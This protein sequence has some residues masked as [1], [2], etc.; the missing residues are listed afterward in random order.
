MISKESKIFQENNS[1]MNTP[2]IM[3]D[4]GTVSDAIKVFEWL[5]MEGEEISAGQVIF[6]VESDKAIM[7]VEAAISGMVFKIVV[8]AGGLVKPGEAVAFITSRDENIDASVLKG[9][10]KL[11]P[12]PASNTQVIQKLVESSHEGKKD[13]VEITPKAFHFAKVNQINTANVK[14]SGPQ[15]RIT[16]QD[17]ESVFKIGAEKLNDEG[18]I[19]ELKGLRGVIARNVSESAQTTA[20]VTTM[21]E[22]RA[23]RFVELRNNLR[24][25]LKSLNI[26][27]PYDLVLAKI[28]A[29]ALLEYS[30]MNSSLTPEGIIQHSAINI[31]IAIDTPEGLIVPVFANVDKRELAELALELQNKLEKAKNKLLSPSDLRGGTFTITNVGMYAI[32]AFTPII[33][34]PECAILGMGRIRETA[35]VADGQIK[36]GRMLTLSLS[37][38]HR[39]VDGA[40]AGRFMSRICE[41]VE[42]PD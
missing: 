28:C 7:E 25:D 27:V 2:I 21:S 29:K 6:R 36:A 16:Y 8:P 35:I 11:Q 22:V 38:D 5:V 34:L 18:M 1:K 9:N 30:Y 14:G 20:T 17:V 39:I 24:N 19:K 3:P 10:K 40:P 33:H 42:N 12:I 13:G 26:E 31:G 23:D 32:D 15:G 41:L 4:L 37:Y